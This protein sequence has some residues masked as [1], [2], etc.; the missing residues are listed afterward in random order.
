M[1]SGDGFH[2]Y[3]SKLG[4]IKGRYA[5]EGAKTNMSTGSEANFKRTI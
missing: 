5:G 2:T 4:P 3:H 1:Q